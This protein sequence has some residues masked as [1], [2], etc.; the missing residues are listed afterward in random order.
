VEV[1]ILAAGIGKRLY[2]LTKNTPK[3]LLKIGDITLLGYSLQTFL[4]LGIYKITLVT[5]HCERE[6]K[7]FVSDFNGLQLNYIFNPYYATKNNIYS[8]FCARKKLKNGCIIFNSDL[9]CDARIIKKVIDSVNISN[10]KSFLIIDELKKL[11]TEE[12]KVKIGND[13]RIEAISKD[14]LPESAQGEYI[15]IAYFSPK[16]GEYLS[17]ILEILIKEKKDQ[18]FYEYAFQQMLI[19]HNIYKI[20]TDGLPWIE[21]DDFNDLKKAKSFILPK[22]CLI[23]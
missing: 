10:E 5:G 2:P 12:M 11:S 9:L 14:I 22:L 18:E 16:G 13:S 19:S 21:I 20:G 15:G 17:K 7:K 6:I 4:E 1:I 3:C 8:L 23:R